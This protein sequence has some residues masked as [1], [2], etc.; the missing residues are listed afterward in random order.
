MVLFSTRSVW[1][2]G[3]VV[4]VLILVA[5]HG[6]SGAALPQAPP[7]VSVTKVIQKTVPE[8][9][10][11]VAHTQAVQEIALVPRVEG[12]LEQV[13][14]RNGSLVHKG[15]L[16]M[17]IQ[18]DQYK[19]AVEAAQ[20]DVDKAQA[21]LVRAKSNVA[22][23]TAKAKLAQAIAS[24]EYQKVQLA[25]M[26]PLAAKMA[27]SQEDYD[28]TRTQYDIAVANVIAAR[29]NLADVELNQK[30]QILDAQGN[31]AQA[32]SQ[33][34]NAQL[35]L[36][37]T[38]ITSPV[39]GIISFLNVDQGNYVSPAKTPTLATV[40]TVDPIKVVFE[41]SESDYLR[42]AP[43]L[44]AMRTTARRPLLQLYLSNGTIYPYKGT[45]ENINRAVDPQTGTISVEASFPNPDALLRP[46]QFARVDF[47][48]A[49]Q[50]NALVVPQA[51]VA[52]L[53]GTP[54]VYVLGPD[55]KVELRTV[56]TGSN[57]GN[58]IVIENG[59]KA[60]ETV[61]VGGL[62]RFKPGGIVA[63]QP[64]PSTAQ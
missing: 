32:Q 25:R 15:Q 62:N 43:R 8:M 7:P 18:Q 21:D 5:C 26:G 6:N 56:E 52:T 57:F 59:V 63:P 34:I 49:Q 35:N 46:G 42:I 55:N 48:I 29:A 53:Q 28:Q 19:A 16:L 61:I 10:E 60:G 36:S 12:T 41:L 3:A 31:L 23:Q 20:G 37:Y 22:D 51:S 27:V 17:V 64:A 4:P 45:P 9:V 2:L 50:H 24:Y 44:L 13:T 1:T 14:F 47:P 11:Y 33:L 54:V 58:D 40:S 38:T 39:T 30:T